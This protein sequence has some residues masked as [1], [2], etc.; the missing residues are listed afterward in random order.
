VAAVVGG[1]DRFRATRA[2]RR[3][4]QQITVLPD[5]EPPISSKP[6]TREGFDITHNPKISA[7]HIRDLTL[8]FVANGESII[9]HG[10]VGVGRRFGDLHQIGPARLGRRARQTT[11][12]DSLRDGPPYPSAAPSSSLEARDPHALAASQRSSGWTILAQR[13]WPAEP[14]FL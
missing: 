2:H 6:C 3:I 8:R 5:S 10:P 14:G 4:F 7:A 11:Q 13:L 12:A 9:L 1:R